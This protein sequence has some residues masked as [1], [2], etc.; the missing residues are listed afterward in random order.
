MP[1]DLNG[2]YAKIERAKKHIRDFD[3]ERIFFL[4]A[5]P[6][7]VITKFNSEQNVTESILGPLPV[8]PNELSL[9]VGDAIQNLRSALDYLVAALVRSIGNEPRFVYFPI[10]ETPEK[11][12]SE[13]EGKTKGMP[14]EAKQLIDSMEPYGG[15]NGNDLWYLH[16][17]NNADKHRL[18][19]TVCANVGQQ[20]IFT[21]SPGGNTFSTL[22]HAPG[23]KEGD[24]LGS[25][26]G[27]SEGEQR[28]NF[29]F[30]IAFGKPE[31]IAGEPVL[32]TLKYM[33]FMVEHIVATFAARF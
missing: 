7:V 19:M 6:Y 3:R 30:D 11:Y 1:L 12:I 18:L 16:T 23:L 4:D 31:S 24:V 20:A 9:M 28:I 32:Q 5:D 15:G 13:S 29:T 10:S 2:C 17:L 14:Q 33:T 26:S 21:L 8:M 25:V 27:N 22:V